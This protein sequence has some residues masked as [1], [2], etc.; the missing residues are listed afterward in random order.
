V[1]RAEGKAPTEAG[2]L[3]VTVRGEAKIDSLTFRGV[4]VAQ[5]P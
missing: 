4:G 5:A 1:A 2:A 3:Y